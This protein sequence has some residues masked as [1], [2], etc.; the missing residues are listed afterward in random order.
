MSIET[1]HLQHALENGRLQLSAGWKTNGDDSTSR[2][3]VLS[4][5]LEG[6]LAGR[7][8]DHGVWPKTILWSISV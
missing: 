5:L 2:P 3:D 4:G 1:D 8:K 7:H 6:L